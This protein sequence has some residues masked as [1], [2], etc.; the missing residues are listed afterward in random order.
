MIF[1]RTI[2]H[3]REPVRQLR[4]HLA[5]QIAVDCDESRSCSTTLT[6]KAFS[7]V[8]ATRLRLISGWN[9]NRAG[10]ASVTDLIDDPATQIRE[11]T[12]HASFLTGNSADAD[13]LVQ[14]SIIR[15]LTYVKDGGTIRNWRAYLYR[16]L[17]NVRADHLGRQARRGSPVVLEDVE[18]QLSVPASQPSELLL[19][20]LG[21]ALER[22]PDGQK[23][24]V[25]LV[26]VDGLSYQDTAERLGIPIG[27]VMS[28]L[29]RG[30]SALRR[31][32]GDVP[33]AEVA[34][35]A[36]ANLERAANAPVAPP[37]WAA[38]G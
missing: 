3:C 20:E 18:H 23:R 21:D 14:E 36:N 27:T 29:H 9:T 37:A 5:H 22:L 10:D 24:V 28:R 11:L 8:T 38:A 12:R 7:Q 33:L 16:I 2:N 34:P 15:A 19:R 32:I 4:K 26:A 25:C 30:R 6:Q 17:R 1:S 13:D 35:V 31:E